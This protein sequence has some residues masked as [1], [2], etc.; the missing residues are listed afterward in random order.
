MKELAKYLLNEENMLPY[1]N[2]SSTREVDEYILKKGNISPCGKYT[3]KTDKE[4][5]TLWGKINKKSE[6]TGDI[7]FSYYKDIE[8]N[9]NLKNWENK[10]LY[11]GKK[12]SIY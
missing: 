3:S 8:I 12:V 6:M 2:Y 1:D 11:L 7:I 9:L 4:Y 5:Y 10:N